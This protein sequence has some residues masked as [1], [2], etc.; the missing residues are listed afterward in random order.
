[1]IKIY[2]HFI[3]YATH[4]NIISSDII[5]FLTKNLNKIVQNIPLPHKIK[6]FYICY[7]G[8]FL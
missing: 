5:A 7:F 1:M 8:I 6:L 4:T 2:K 3:L